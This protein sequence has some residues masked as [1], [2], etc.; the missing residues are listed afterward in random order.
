MFLG[1]TGLVGT[2]MYMAP[3]L[4][5]NQLKYTQVGNYADCYVVVVYFGKLWSIT[6]QL[7]MGIEGIVGSGAV[8]GSGLVVGRPAAGVPIPAAL[9]VILKLAIISIASK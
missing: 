8:G 6:V 3:E 4:L 2:A 9:Q 1:E 7:L 5:K